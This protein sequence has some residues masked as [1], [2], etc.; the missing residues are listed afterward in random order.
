MILCIRY[1]QIK[2]KTE[3]VKITRSKLV[4]DAKMVCTNIRRDT[5]S[6][7]VEFESIRMKSKASN[8][9][10]NMIRN[11]NTFKN[12]FLNWML[13]KNHSF[14]VY[15]QVQYQSR[16]SYALYLVGSVAAK[17]ARAPV[18]TRINSFEVSSCKTTWICDYILMT[19][20]E[21]K[22]SKDERFLGQHAVL[23]TQ[24]RFTRSKI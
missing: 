13:K 15:S 8:A 5:S 9:K 18:Q 17:K 22:L 10:P 1:N 11:Q 23:Y 14:K 7:F 6:N 19:K 3:I 24:R 4:S 21:D 12:D 20:L 16:Q 2:L